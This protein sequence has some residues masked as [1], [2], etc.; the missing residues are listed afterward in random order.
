MDV[1]NVGHISQLLNYNNMVMEM[2]I[3]D[4][5]KIV[6]KRPVMDITSLYPTE[7]NFK[8][9]TDRLFPNGKSHIARQQLLETTM[10]KIIK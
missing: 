1:N 10:D 2:H 9:A 6:A 7:H 5:S 3:V 8:D 4:E